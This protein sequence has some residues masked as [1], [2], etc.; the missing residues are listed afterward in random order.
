MLNIVVSNNIKPY[1]FN[2][3]IRYFVNLFTYIGKTITITYSDIQD[4]VFRFYV[5]NKYLLV[6]FSDFLNSS[7]NTISFHHDGIE[8]YPLVPI[9]FIDYIHSSYNKN[10]DD[11]IVYRCREYGNGRIRRGI[12][13]NMVSGLGVNTGLVS[14]DRFMAE[15]AGCLAGIFVPGACERMLDR[16]QLQFMLRGCCTISPCIPEWLPGVGRLVAGIHYIECRDDYCDLPDIIDR[17]RGD[18]GIAE[19]VGYNAYKLNR[20]A[21]PYYLTN[22]LVDRVTVHGLL[23]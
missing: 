14:Y 9:S 1:Y 20:V 19:G 2:N 4:T 12:V 17:I 5:G 3:H 11:N 18:R 13:R 15:A 10:K 7:K 8:G 23:S 22:Y 16:G 21:N 6:N